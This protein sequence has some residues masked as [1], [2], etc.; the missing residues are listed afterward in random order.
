MLT[1]PL[2]AYREKRVRSAQAIPAQ[3]GKVLFRQVRVSLTLWYSGVLA[4]ALFLFGIALYF[5]VQQSLFQSVQDELKAQTNF[6]AQQ[7]Q[8]HFSKSSCPLTGN[9]LAGIEPPF[10][11]L[12]PPSESKPP[13]PFYLVCYNAKADPVTSAEVL[14]NRNYLTGPETYLNPSLAQTV[15]KNYQQTGQLEASDKIDGGPQVGHI[16]RYGQVV[17]NPE[18]SQVLGII[19]L[20]R[21]VEDLYTALEVLRNL[22][23]GLGL[24][25]LIAAAAGGLFMAERALIPTR[26]AF[27]RQQTFIAD[28][29]H[30]LRTP[31]T[32]LKADAEVLLRSSESLAA[33]DA[34]LL[35]DIVVEADH[36]NNIAT[37]LLE[38]A[39]LDAGSLPLEREI[40]DLTELGR[41]SIRRVRVLA[42]E[43]KITLKE[44]FGL[45]LLVN[46]DGQ[47]LEQ[48]TLI[49][50]DNALKYT[51]TGGTIILSTRQAEGNAWLEVSDSG[52]GIAA[53]HLARL[54][55]RFY[56][57][58]KARSREEGGTG[59]G[60][61]LA[62]GIITLHQGR[63]EIESVPGQGTKVS[64]GLPLLTPSGPSDSY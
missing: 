5:S 17:T 27:A 46:G 10:S 14:N 58:D 56:R 38:L 51:P 52:I 18:G 13:I 4:V 50:L 11:Q 31:L 55:E 54:G 1:T 28:A 32:L 61:A 6:I 7:W 60:L 15:L 64:L 53:E 8:Q 39:R 48:A 41:R 26:R 22:L 42:S 2:K 9:N 16:F 59:L 40:I 21:S 29:S 37:N 25:T 63:F 44:R 45:E 34:E 57:V 20:G 49:L 23:V 3:P 12:N 24:V 35:E 30:E 19:Q 33:E 43:K 36:L 47:L 62:Q